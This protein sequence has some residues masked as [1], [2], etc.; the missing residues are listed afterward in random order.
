MNILLTGYKGF[1]G[2]NMLNALKD[3]H[4]VYTYEW[5]ERFP[6]SLSGL[7]WVLHIGAISYTTEQD[8]DKLMAQNYEFSVELFEKCKK[9]R[10]N[11]QYSSS[12][13]VYGLESDFKET[14]KCQ[15]K[16]GYAWSKYLFDRYV[17]MAEPSV[18]IVQGFRYFNVYGPNEDHK[19]KQA[20]PYHQFRKQAKETGVIKLFEGSEDFNR[21]FVPVE[22]VIDIH[23]KF[24][25]IPKS[26]IFNLG[27]G[28]TKSFLDVA[29]EIAAEYNAEIKYIPMPEILKD[30]YQ[31][32]TCADLTLL[33]EVL[34]HHSK[35]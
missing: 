29:K 21:D 15:P 22:T 12:A 9:E 8:V 16:N 1:I 10:V 18:N 11:L 7:D 32:Y 26:G 24:L 30:S 34:C 33:N 19:G 31:K 20:S 6:Y 23:K 13:S 2:S 25:N 5:G 17:R 28:K 35:N 27:T 14:S 3:E 4:T